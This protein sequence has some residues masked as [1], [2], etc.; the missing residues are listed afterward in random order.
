MRL[1]WILFLALPAFATNCTLPLGTNTTR[2]LSATAGLWTGGCAGIP[3]VGDTVADITGTGTSKLVI[4]QNWEVGT[5]PSPAADVFKYSAP[6]VVNSGVTLTIRGS[7]VLNNATATFNGGSI[8]QLNPSL[9]ADRT[10]AYTWHL[11]TY[12]QANAYIIALGTSSSHVTLRSPKD[13]PTDGQWRFDLGGYLGFGWRGSTTADPAAYVDVV[14]MGDAT[15]PSIIGNTRPP[16]GGASTVYLDH[17]TVTNSGGLNVV[18]GSTATNAT[19]IVTN[20]STAGTLTPYSLQYDTVPTTIGTGVRLIANNVF[21]KQVSASSDL[22]MGAAGNLR[23]VTFTNNYSGPLC[24]MGA[25]YAWAQVS[26]NLFRQTNAT[27]GTVHPTG[28]MS[29][30]YVLR[31]AYPASGGDNPHFLMGNSN[32]NLPTGYT[33]SNIVFEDVDDVTLDSGEG[34]GLT[35]NP[36]AAM[37]YKLINSIV[38]PSKTGRSVAELG[39]ILSGV[40][41]AIQSFDHNTWFGG[42][43]G[44]GSGLNGF[45]ALQM[46][47]GVASTGNVASLQA[48]VIYGPASGTAQFF[49]VLPKTDTSSMTQDVVTPANADYNAAFNTTATASCTNCVNQ[50]NGY[51]GKWSATPGTHDLNNTNPRFADSLRNIALWDTKYLGNPLGTTWSVSSVAYAVGNVVSHS[52]AGVYGGLPVNFRCIAAHTS[53]ATTEPDMGTA[54]RTNWEYASLSDL[55]TAILTGKTFTDGAI[56]CVGCPPVRALIKWVQRGV[57][58]Q[59]LVLYGY[60][61]PGDANA[62]KNPGAVP[63]DRPVTRGAWF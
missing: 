31:D 42:A 30:A 14:N 48:N 8:I 17:W 32:S 52:A 60:T 19:G 10:V 51:V 21:D 40:P 57:T 35:A 26:D 43:P 45:G 62:V 47:T 12:Y 23:D 44:S 39:T 37:Q 34:F 63:M 6:I 5:S 22:C 59:N 29:F 36:T 46:E 4:D 38:L 11:S 33:M 56:G 2:N 61:F 15:H 27:D 3:G 16:G 9:A 24:A 7:V 18:F 28:D 58:P 1:I 49:K 20:S 53:G 41:N 54:W 13:G 50:G 25:Q 55:R